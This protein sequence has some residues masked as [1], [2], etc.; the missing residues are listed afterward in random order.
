MQN[1]TNTLEL[2]FKD[3]SGRSNKIVVVAPVED[4]DQETA[5][6]VMQTIVDANL[7]TRTGQDLHASIDGARYVTRKVE[8]IFS[9]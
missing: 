4:L 5:Q 8:E 2:L 9:L 1:V 6:G 7:F 3:T